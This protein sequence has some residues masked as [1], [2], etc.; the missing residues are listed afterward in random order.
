MPNSKGNMV[1][2]GKVTVVT[3]PVLKRVMRRQHHALSRA[4]LSCIKV[5]PDVLQIGLEDNYSGYRGPHESF[6]RNLAK[7]TDEH[8]IVNR[9]LRR[10][11]RI[12][13]LIRQNGSGQF[14]WSMEFYA[15]GQKKRFCALTAIVAQS[16]VWTIS[17]PI[18]KGEVPGMPSGEMRQRY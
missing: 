6:R 15:P 4:Y 11:S 2:Y 8:R 10:S 18:M 3:D 14:D 1:M 17:L 12:K 16:G 7:G 5:I 9:S 13:V